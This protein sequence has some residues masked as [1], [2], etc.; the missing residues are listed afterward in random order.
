MAK[1]V[2]SSN[3][4]YRVGEMVLTEDDLTFT[5]VYKGETFT[6]RYPTPFELS[7]IEAD[8]AKRLGGM[9]RTSFPE[10]HVQRVEATAYVDQLVDRDESPNWFKTAWTCYDDRCIQTLYGG[11]LRFRSQF[12][13]RFKGD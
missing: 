1:S 8:I 5:V 3:Q 9:P 4:E 6:L 13:E 10:E 12:Q 2:D 11:Y 7:L